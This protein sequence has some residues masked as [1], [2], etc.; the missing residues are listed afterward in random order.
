MASQAAK[1]RWAAPGFVFDPAA[2]ADYARAFDNA[3]TIHAQRHVVERH[4]GPGSDLGDAGAL[5]LV[6]GALVALGGPAR[7][8]GAGKHRGV[9]AGAVVVQTGEWCAE[10]ACEP[11]AARGER[12][13]RSAGEVALL[14]ANRVE[15][16]TGERDMLRFAPVG[17]AGER[18]LFRTPAELVEAARGEERQHLEGLGA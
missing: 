13:V 14:E 6:V 18:E 7:G 1:A 12:L 2:K 16:A 15:H 17:R 5:H 9:L 8:K 11:G 10:L 3:A 4:T